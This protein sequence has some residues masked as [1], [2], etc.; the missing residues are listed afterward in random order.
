MKI[1]THLHTRIYS[2]CSKLPPAALINTAQQRNLDGI[3]I[4]EH[5][6]IWPEKDFSLLQ[7]EASDLKIF[8]GVEVSCTDGFDYLIF[9]SMDFFPLKN[10]ITPQEIMKI[11]DK[12]D[13]FV[14]IAHPYR[15]PEDVIPDHV[16]DLH[17]DGVEVKSFNMK[18]DIQ[19]RKAFNLAQKMNCIPIAGS[20]AHGTGR[21]GKY[22]I[23]LEK[24]AD[25]NRELVNGLKGGNFK[26]FD[27]V[28]D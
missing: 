5:N 7:E 24:K 9:G 13:N 27:Y 8:R 2:A 21:I 15:S 3:I 19:Q 23:E 4:T 18:A 17:L 6:Q 11:A 16:Y 22:G 14:A 12:K 28:S 25:N 1:D 20:D 10:D 26:I